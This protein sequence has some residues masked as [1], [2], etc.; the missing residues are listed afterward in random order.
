MKKAKEKSQPSMKSG[1][2]VSNATPFARK[3]SCRE[4][5]VAFCGWRVM[6]RKPYCRVQRGYEMAKKE[7]VGGIILQ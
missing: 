7:H 2:T 1:F 5:L 3:S 4:A 6:H